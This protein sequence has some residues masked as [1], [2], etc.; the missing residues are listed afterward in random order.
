MLAEVT[1]LGQLSSIKAAEA[2]ED[3]VLI[4]DGLG[5]L[6][7]LP[8]SGSTGAVTRSVGVCTAVRL[9]PSGLSLALG[10]ADGWVRVFA[11]RSLLSVDS[12][13]VEPIASHRQHGDAC[14]EHLCWSADSSKLYSGCRGGL[15][16]EVL[17]S[18]PQPAAESAMAHLQ[19]LSAKLGV[20]LPSADAGTT[21]VAHN[22]GYR[23]LQ[24]S[25]CLSETSSGSSDM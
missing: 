13:P 25:S 3:A 17:L 18:A 22:P 8:A 6:H 20:W 23:T 7:V 4:T 12:R 14:I 19:Q 11:L 24:L 21:I 10:L 5:Q 2:A 9:S 15:V 1:Q 16:A